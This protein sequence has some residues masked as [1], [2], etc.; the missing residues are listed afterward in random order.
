MIERL[1]D[2]DFWDLFS[3]DS[4]L[5]TTKIINKMNVFSTQ[6]LVD[7][8][9]LGL[10]FINTCCTVELSCQY[11]LDHPLHPLL[12]PISMTGFDGQASK[13]ILHIFIPPELEVDGRIFPHQPMLVTNLGKHDVILG[14]NWL[15]KHNIWLD[16][17][18]ERL[19]WPTPQRW[20]FYTTH[21]E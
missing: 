9:A 3:G 5:V 4:F 12:K 14:K 17:K 19:I 10:T 16:I 1:Q 8:G 6:S 21:C 20:C 15:A 7:S 2:V 13:P 18:N 11:G